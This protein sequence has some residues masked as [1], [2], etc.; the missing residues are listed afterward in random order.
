MD[1]LNSQHN[2]DAA[3]KD[4]GSDSDKG[5][6]STI[7]VF[8]LKDILKFCTK[9]YV[10]LGVNAYH[11]SEEIARIHNVQYVSIKQKF[12]TAQEY[13]LLALKHRTGY[14]LTPL[15]MKIYKPVDQAEELAGVK[16]ALS[17]NPVYKTLIAEFDGHPLPPEQ[18]LSARLIRSFGVKDYA[19]EK[20]ASIFLNNL[21]TAGVVQDN[22]L[23]FGGAVPV[24]GDNSK[25]DASNGVQDPPALPKMPPPGYIE[26]PIPLPSGGRAYLRI[27]ENYKTEDCE[28][29]SRFVDAL[30]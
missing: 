24:G 13:G 4:N 30:K 1:Q 20:T 22:I 27:P 12:S 3:P 18:S 29:I 2:E 16:E 10:E 9:I 15:F 6:R 8:P 5:K 7:P 17:A 11:P 23:K 19:S 26:I 25:L 28:R 14:K 21:R